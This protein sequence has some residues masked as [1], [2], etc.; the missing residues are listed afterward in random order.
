M[1]R[2]HSK[3]C[4]TDTN[5]A[6]PKK[7]NGLRPLPE[8][9]IRKNQTQKLFRW[10]TED[11]GHSWVWGLQ[12]VCSAALIRKKNSQGGQFTQPYHVMA[13]EASK[14]QFRDVLITD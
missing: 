14:S 5:A 9:I 2:V 7:I 4:E 11:Q 12:F 10:E 1:L 8:V 3:A 6:L 13:A